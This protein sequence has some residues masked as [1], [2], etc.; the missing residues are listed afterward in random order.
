MD[1]QKIFT[2]ATDVR[3]EFEHWSIDGEKLNHLYMAYNHISHVDRFLDTAR[4][5]FPR[6]CCGIATIYLKEILTEGTVKRGKY[7][8]N[9]HTFLLLNEEVIVDITADQYGGPSVFMG[10]IRYPWSF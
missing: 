7:E 6:L 4:K 5:I 8:R 3:N 2:I 9:N 1:F 10:L